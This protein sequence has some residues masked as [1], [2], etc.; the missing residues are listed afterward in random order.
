MGFGQATLK[1]EGRNFIKKETPTDVLSIEF[2]K[3]FYGW[4]QVRGVAKLVPTVSVSTGILLFM[5]VQKL[6]GPEISRF[7]PYMLQFLDN[8]RV[9]FF[10]N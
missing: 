6:Y 4:S 7:L 1:A 2:C 5:D 8:L 3:F 10:S 9:F